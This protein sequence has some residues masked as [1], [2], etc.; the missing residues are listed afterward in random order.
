MWYF[1]KTNV[2][3][4]NGDYDDDSR[5]CGLGTFQSNLSS[6]WVAKHLLISLTILIF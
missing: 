2:N 6:I 3:Y 5:K 1:K 4:D